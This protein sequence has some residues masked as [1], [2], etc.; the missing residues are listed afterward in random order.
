MLFAQVSLYNCDNKIS[1]KLHG[2]SYNY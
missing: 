1:K 2:K